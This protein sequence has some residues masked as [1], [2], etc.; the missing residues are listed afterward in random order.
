MGQMIFINA[1]DNAGAGGDNRC[2]KTSEPGTIGK[3][4]CC[5][6]DLKDGKMYCTICDATNPPSNCS[7][8]YPH[9]EYLKIKKSKTPK[10]LETDL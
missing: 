9:F 7:D 10:V 8:R 4:E 3:V 1:V 5:D 6:I 2:Y